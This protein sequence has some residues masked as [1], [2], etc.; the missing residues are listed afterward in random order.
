MGH[1]SVI[2]NAHLRPRFDRDSARAKDRLALGVIYDLYGGC[3]TLRG[4]SADRSDSKERESRQSHKRTQNGYPDRSYYSM[5][6]HK[7]PP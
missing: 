1:G 4:L 6:C 5:G 3:A 2:D 7:E